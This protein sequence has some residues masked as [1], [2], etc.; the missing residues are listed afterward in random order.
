MNMNNQK[1]F[2]NIVLIV[3]I[4]A[5]I[6]VGG[7]FVFVKKSEPITQQPTPTTTQNPT[8]TATPKNET[9]NWEVY[10]NEKYGIEFKHPTGWYIYDGIDGGSGLAIYE[11][12][13]GPGLPGVTRLMNIYRHGNETTDVKTYAEKN[14]LNTPI[15]TDTTSGVLKKEQGYVTVAQIQS[16][17]IYTKTIDRDGPME[18]YNPPCDWSSYKNVES[19]VVRTYVPYKS[20]IFEV[21]VN[22]GGEISTDAQK[23][24]INPQEETSYIN[25]YKLIL[26]TFK[27]TN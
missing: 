24:K 25:T 18:C 22:M 23:K 20:A 13:V 10:R 1:G 6:A 21:S 17:Q 11:R 19:L 16:Y 9:A 3:V 12:K 2:A 4:V 7:Y 8:P 15:A 5:I 26:T 14:T 27:F